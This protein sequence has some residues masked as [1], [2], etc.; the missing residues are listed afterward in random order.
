MKKWSLLFLAV[1][2]MVQQTFSQCAMCKV[3]AEQGSAEELEFGYNINYGIVFIMVI[4][5]II[6]F[7]FFRK[8]IANL[9]REFRRKKTDKK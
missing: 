2:V 9:Y 4:P 3:L 1:F 7:I 8:Q 5:Y 6:I